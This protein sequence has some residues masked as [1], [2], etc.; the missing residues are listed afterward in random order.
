MQSAAEIEQ[1]K[2]ESEHSDSDVEFWK[3]DSD[4]TVT[5]VFRERE[6]CQVCN[7][8]RFVFVMRAGR[9]RCADCDR[10]A[11]TAV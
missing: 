2:F 6:L 8:P 3:I 7:L 4:M 1:E 11:F 10:R 9:T 5:L